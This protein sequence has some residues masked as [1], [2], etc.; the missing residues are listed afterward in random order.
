MTDFGQIEKEAAQW[1]ARQDRGL[2]LKEQAA[3]DHWLAQGAAHKVS[4]LRLKA[5]WGQA[6]GL[7]AL[8]ASLPRPR[9]ALSRRLAMTVP[10]A[11][12]LG[13]LAACLFLAIG[14]VVAHWPAPQA[15]VLSTS[16]GQHRR[17]TLSDGTRIE[18]DGNTG[19]QT[20]QTRSGRTVTLDYGEAYFEVVHDEK[21]P[22]TVYAG[23]RKIT[24]LGTKFSVSR[25]GDQVEVVV[26][27]GRVRVD[28]LDGPSIIAEKDKPIAGAAETGPSGSPPAAGRAGPG[29][30]LLIFNDEALDDVAREFNRFNKKQIHVAANARDIKIGGSFR[31][32][33]V[34]RFKVL[35]EQ[36]FDVKVKESGGDI[37]VTR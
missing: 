25:N 6:D 7:C 27:E 20:L 2:D 18:L 24:D 3:F 35:L 34:D 26:R 11:V 31:I 9:A 30:G 15:Q 22:F 33:N 37:F 16:A 36:G 17:V 19:L 14:L 1:L 23:N 32:D 5:A 13:A 29:A 28:A 10:A 4:Y 8:R 21:H 12:K